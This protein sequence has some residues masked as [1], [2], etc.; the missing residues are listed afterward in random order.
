MHLL[1]SVRKNFSYQTRVFIQKYRV[2]KNSFEKI[3]IK[4]ASCVEVSSETYTGLPEDATAAAEDDSTDL[5]FSWLNEEAIDE[6]D[7]WS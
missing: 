2:K 1:C 3:S 5:E 7:S 4:A 6:E